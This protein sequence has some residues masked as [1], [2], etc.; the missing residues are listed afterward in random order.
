MERI[1]VTHVQIL[2]DLFPNL[3]IHRFTNFQQYSALGHK[4]KAVLKWFEFEDVDVLKCPG[5]SR[6]LNLIKNLWTIIK[7]KVSR[8][9]PGSLAELKKIIKE[10]WCKDIDEK[11]CKNLLDSM[12][13]RIQNVVKKKN[14]HTKY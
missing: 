6:Y 10:I 13:C 1:S 5:N 4:S 8:S 11:V 7:Q 2:L 14:Y 9:N 3:S 12:P